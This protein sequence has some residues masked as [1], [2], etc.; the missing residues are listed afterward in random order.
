[1]SLWEFSA[2]V[3]GFKGFNSAPDEKPSQ[4]KPITEE[5]F[6]ATMARLNGS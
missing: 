3:E 1:M 2:C 4:A 5:L 6:I